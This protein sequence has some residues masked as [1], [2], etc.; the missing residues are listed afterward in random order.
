MEWRGLFVGVWGLVRGLAFPLT[1]LGMAPWFEGATRA[2]SM[3]D[4]LRVSGEPAVEARDT[5]RT[6]HPASPSEPSSYQGPPESSR[7]RH[8]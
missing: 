1:A 4:M 5:N 2:V 7:T 8:H 6:V 3:E